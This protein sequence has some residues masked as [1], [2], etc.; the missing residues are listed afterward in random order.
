MKYKQTG[1][2]I[3]SEIIVPFTTI[4]VM[5]AL[6]GYLAM[7]LVSKASKLSPNQLQK[8]LVPAFIFFLIA[9]VIIANVVVSLGVFIAYVI[10]GIDLHEFFPNL[11]K[12]ELSF[13]NNQLWI[14][15]LFFSIAFFYV[16]WRKSSAKEQQLREQLLKFQYERLKSQV[17][18]HFLFNSLNT[19]SELVYQDAKRADNYIQKLSNIYR[20]ILENEK[21]ELVPLK[22]EIEFVQDFFN[23]QKERDGE[24]IVLNIDL[25]NINRYK[26][27]PASLQMLVENALKHN[28]CSLDVPLNISIGIENDNIIV[29]NN[30]Q[31]KSILG[32]TTQMGLQNLKERLKLISEKELVIEED[33]SRF[34]VQVPVIR[35]SE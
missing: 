24:K 14:W 29:T 33:N 32:Q 17:N 8:R 3:S 18:P 7:F 5:S 30:K 28:A 4:F 16:L 22:E 35:T 31:K 27:M 23:L 11:I 20:Y 12:Y 34:I 2:Y 1:K 21:T 15:L 25:N 9:T 6:I 13:A 19:L 10:K 26:I